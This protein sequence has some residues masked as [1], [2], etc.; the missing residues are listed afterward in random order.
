[1]FTTEVLLKFLQIWSIF[2][3]L[4]FNFRDVFFKLVLVF[5]DQLDFPSQKVKKK[6]TALY[7]HLFLKINLKCFAQIYLLVVNLEMAVAVSYL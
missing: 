7:S 4:F 6:E 2:V 1:M 3:E 5:S